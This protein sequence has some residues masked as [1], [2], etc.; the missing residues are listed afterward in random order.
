MVCDFKDPTTL[1]QTLPTELL[2]RILEKVETPVIANLYKICGSEPEVNSAVSC[3]AENRFNQFKLTDYDQFLISRNPSL[4]LIDGYP[5]AETWLKLC[6][7]SACKLCL[8]K[9]SNWGICDEC[10]GASAP[11]RR[12]VP[13]ANT[14]PLINLNNESMEFETCVSMGKFH[15]SCNVK[16]L[17]LGDHYL[18]FIDTYEPDYDSCMIWCNANDYTDIVVASSFSSLKLKGAEKTITSRLIGDCIGVHFYTN[19]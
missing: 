3:I 10:L 8:T 16:V 6:E 12:L 7:L 13:S 2:L 17:F 1:L 19:N 5:T 15:V 9:R 4:K 11:L 18:F 14:P